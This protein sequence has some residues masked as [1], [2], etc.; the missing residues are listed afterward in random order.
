MGEDKDAVIGVI[1]KSNMEFKEEE[2]K[3][4]VIGVL[5]KG[6]MEF[7]KKNGELELE[8]A[9]LRAIN[10]DL[11]HKL[12]KLNKQ[13]ESEQESKSIKMGKSKM[14]KLQINTQKNKLNLWT[15]NPKNKLRNLLL[16]I[17]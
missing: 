7:K 12:I 3:D 11:R 14:D 15:K 2:D 5:R 10:T 4:V 13:L 9:R 17:T 16:E 6:N 1:C 8:N